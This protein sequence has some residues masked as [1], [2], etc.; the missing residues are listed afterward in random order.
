MTGEVGLGEW[1]LRS[2]GVTS[3]S[4]TQNARRLYVLRKLESYEASLRYYEAGLLG[5]ETWAAWR[6]ALESDFN[7][8]EFREVWQ[9]ASRFYADPFVRF[10]ESIHRPMSGATG[11][12]AV[13]PAST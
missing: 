2:R 9:V 5:K 3:S 1:F 7:L 11:A 4:A 6:T 13:R 12:S 10:I 8:P